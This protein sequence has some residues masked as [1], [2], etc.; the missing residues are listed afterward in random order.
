MNFKHGGAAHG[1]SPEYRVW[2]SMK[3]RCHC[4]SDT[5]YFK[6][7]ARGIRVCVQWRNSFENFL[8]DMGKRPTSKHQLD[9][10]NGLQGYNPENCR[11]ATCKEQ[12]QNTI[13]SL[14]WHI[15]GQVFNSCGDA[16]IILGVGRSTIRGWCQGK[17]MRQ[18]LGCYT[19]R[20]YG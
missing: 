1:R 12:N 18:R 17:G 16:A 14:R 11:W 8:V 20:V 19:E 10:K 7:G 13:K 5:F 15:N 2:Q 3:Q 6:Y 9:R 4:A